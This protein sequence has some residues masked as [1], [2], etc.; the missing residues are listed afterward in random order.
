MEKID[1]HKTYKNLYTPSAKAVQLI[2]APAFNFAMSIY[3]LTLNYSL[4]MFI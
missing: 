3:Y 4:I 2:E 1:L